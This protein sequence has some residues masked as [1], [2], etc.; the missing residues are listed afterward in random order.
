MAAI[1]PFDSQ[2]VEIGSQASET[3]TAS[4]LTSRDDLTAI[5]AQSDLPDYVHKSRWQ[6]FGIDWHIALSGYQPIRCSKREAQSHVWTVENGLAIET[7]TGNKRHFLYGL[8][9]SLKRPNPFASNTPTKRHH[10]LDSKVFRQALL[11]WHILDQV[12]LRKATSD[13]HNDLLSIVNLD[14][15]LLTITS[16]STMREEVITLYMTSLGIV[17]GY[18]AKAKSK[19]TLS[20]DIWTAGNKLPLLGIVAHYIDYN[21]ELKVV[22]L[23][24]LEI[25]GS[26][27]G[28]NIAAHLLS[29]IER[30]N[31]CNKLGF[32]MADN[33]SS[34]DKALKI[35]K[36]SI[37]T[38]DPQNTV[39]VVSTTDEIDEDVAQFA[40]LIRTAE[41]EKRLHYWRLSSSSK[42]VAGDNSALYQVV[43][44]GGVRWN[45]TFAMIE[46]LIQLRDPVDYYAQREGRLNSH[47]KED[48]LTS[49]D[50]KDLA[51]FK[52]L[53][54]PLKFLS[55]RQQGNAINGSH[56]ALWEWLSTL[57]M[58][59]S[60]FEEKR[61][62]TELCESS[63]Y[64]ACITLGWKKLDKYYELSDYAPAY[65]AAIALHPAFKAAWFRKHW[66][67]SH[68]SWID[69]AVATTRKEEK[70]DE[71]QRYLDAP[72]EKVQNPILWW[73]AHEAQ[74]PLLSEM[75]FDLLA[76]PAMSAECER[77]Q[78]PVTAKTLETDLYHISSDRTV[79]VDEKLELTHWVAIKAIGALSSKTVELSQQHVLY[80]T[81]EYKYKALQEQNGRRKVQPKRGHHLVDRED[82]KQP[83]IE[84]PLQDI[85][86][87]T[88][89]LVPA[90]DALTL[91]DGAGQQGSMLMPDETIDEVLKELYLDPKWR[92]DLYFSCSIFRDIQGLEDL[93][94]RY[95]DDPLIGSVDD[96]GDTAVL[97][98][99]TEDNGLKTLRWL[100]DRGDPIHQ[101]NHY[102]RTPLMEAALWGRLETVQYLSQQSINLGARDANGMQA[103]DLAAD[104]Q[105][106]ATERTVR[107][108]AVY[109]EPPKASRQREQI[110]ALLKR[111]TSPIPEP[112]GIGMEAQ[113]RT[114]F[115]RR[116][117]GKYFSS[118]PLDHVDA[119]R[120]SPR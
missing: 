58:C 104:T 84:P 40:A 99:A 27:S 3:A 42:T 28:E 120:L 8:I 51:D 62:D 61:T 96:E 74:Y 47:I 79:G 52:E 102:G 17:K 36:Q 57:D 64:K 59:L 98:A 68:P 24:L 22:L 89:E 35:L 90:I 108:G 1:H 111:L 86:S 85:E 93:C 117:D 49:D 72:I 26:H 46:R 109:R 94:R 95:P 63:F 4:S 97:Y 114:F 100:Q 43:R 69:K 118:H 25:N 23:A 107:S 10:A 60:A 38:I 11:K 18:L 56:G 32:F 66:L 16:H 116:N 112:I 101:S 92:R 103:V 82:I 31:L 77:P 54:E 113:R 53:L 44:D 12:S 6:P 9:A 13:A 115:E 83:Q 78:P 48:T 110:Q 91:K 119:K 5:H 65:R 29:V 76:A 87:S 73:Q 81:L 15:E 70:A 7:I 20:F 67:T 71:L 14:T 33:A 30:F 75:A 34:N 21:Y 37:S 19:V 55:T 80:Q 105:R 2:Q 106:N 45:S 50:W 88:D 41:E 39:F